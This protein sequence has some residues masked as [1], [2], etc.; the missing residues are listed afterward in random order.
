MMV[1]FLCF[2]VS[3]SSTPSR[4]HVPLFCIAVAPRMNHFLILHYTQGEKNMPSS[5]FLNRNFA[6]LWFG[7]SI[8]QLGDAIIEVTLPIWVG[9]L[10]NDPAHVAL[11]A[12]TEV[13]PACCLGPFAGACA[14]RW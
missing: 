13:L 14:D 9:I 5:W 6:Y 1:R 2:A 3:R 12:A 4:S 7:Q 10:T 8:S 11:V